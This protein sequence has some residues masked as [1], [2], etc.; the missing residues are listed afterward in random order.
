[1]NVDCIILGQGLCGTLMSYE[2]YKRKKSFVVIDDGNRLASSKVA[3]GLINPVTGKRFV[4]SWKYDELIHSAIEVYEELEIVLERKLLRK[5]DMIQL[6]TG[7]DEQN[8]FQKRLET[9]THLSTIDDSVFLKTYF[10]FDYGAGKIAPCFVVDS[11]ELLAGWRNELI[12]DNCLLEETFDWNNCIAGSKGI[13]Y[14]HFSAST[15]ICCEGA[16]SFHNPYFQLL[17]F[18]LNKGQAL[19]VDI[20]ELPKDKIFKHHFKFIPLHDNLFWVGSSFEWKYENTQPTVS[21]TATVPNYLRKILCLPF[22]VIEAAASERPSSV[23]YRPFVGFHPHQPAI[24]LL[25]GM[26]SKGFLQAPFFARQLASHLFNGTEILS[27]VDVKRFSK[28]LS[29]FGKA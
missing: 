7:A 1:M 3:A 24:G 22:T 23:D 17:P 29:R 18:S 15:I 19:I 26:G 16:A 28:I 9:E 5:L 12:A 27:D 21:F 4:K 6:H 2:L 20:P 14:K 13:R 25:N 11:S 10:N 8:N